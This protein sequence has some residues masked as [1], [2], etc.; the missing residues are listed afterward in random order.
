MT[1]KIYEIYRKFPKFSD[2]RK[3]CCNLPEIQEKRPNLGV[4][5]QKDASGIA[6]SGDPD[7]DQTGPLGAF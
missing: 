1:G 4:F 6:N 3:H 7:Q 5:R 2:A